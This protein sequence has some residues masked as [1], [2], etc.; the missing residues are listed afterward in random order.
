MSDFFGII[1]IA[2]FVV[3]AIAWQFILPTVGLL[4]LIGWLH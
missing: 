1:F 2:A 3:A 4:Y